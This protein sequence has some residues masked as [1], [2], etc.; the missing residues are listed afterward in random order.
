[1]LRV[2]LLGLCTYSTIAM[3]LNSTEYNSYYQ[4]YI[5]K[6]T[7]DSSFSKALEASGRATHHFYQSV[8]KS[9]LDYAY[10]EGKWTIKDILLHIID[11]ERVFAYRALR[12]A[13]QDKTELA[14]F[15]QDDYVLAADATKR[16]IESLLNEYQSVRNATVTLFNS[17]KDDELKSI[18]TASGSPVSVRAIGYII[19][20]HE[21][22]HKRIITE[23][24]L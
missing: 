18:G 2:F 17:F 6:A 23:R 14:G 8:P 3:K 22:H 21:N 4:P 5:D 16:S 11:A 19:I 1:M 15:E 24:Y 13:R 20:G 9:K 7:I 12:I 10:S